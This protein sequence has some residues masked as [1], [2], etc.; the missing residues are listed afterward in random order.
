MRP[1]RRTLREI[2]TRPRRRGFTLVEVLATL[3]LLSIT[4]PAIMMGFSLSTN[5]A[6]LARRRTEAGALAE[7]KLNELIATGLWQSGSQTGP[8]DN[9]PD[10]QWSASASPWGQGQG[11]QA[12]NI[13]QQLDVVVSWGAPPQQSITVSTLVYQSANAVGDSGGVP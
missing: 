4:L 9:S 3:L 13:V 2:S 1:P 5:A 10:Y 8:F 12:S 7:S 6:D 11:V